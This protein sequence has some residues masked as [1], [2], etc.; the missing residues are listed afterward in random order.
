[1]SHEMTCENCGK[2]FVAKR[3]TAKYCGT[4]CRVE[5]NRNLNR[6]RID[7]DKKND[8]VWSQFNSYANLMYNNELSYDATVTLLAVKKAIDMYVPKQSW[9]LCDGCKMKVHV[10][11]PEKQCGCSKPKWRRLDTSG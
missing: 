9:W 2:V 1:M 7:I 11:L 5:Y 3:S 10:E 4:A 6:Y 8:E